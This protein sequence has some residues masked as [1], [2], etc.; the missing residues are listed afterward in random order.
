MERG[1]KSSTLADL[2]PL[3][4][5]LY[6]SAPAVRFKQDGSWV[7]RS[8]DEVLETVRSLSLGLIELGVERGDKVSILAN[9]RPEWTYFDFAALSAGAVVV[10]IYQTNSPQECQYVLENS[11]AKV[12]VVEDDEQMEKIR[13]VRDRLPLLEH[14]VRMT[15]AGEDAI[16]LEDLAARG[17]GRDPAEWEARWQAVTPEDI[18]TFIYTSGTTGPPKGCII[19][20]GNYRAMLDMVNETS[21]IEEED[22]TYLYLPLAHS[23]AL[24]IQLGSFDLGATI[25]YWERDPLKILPNLGELK[26]TYFPSVPRIFEKIYT[27]ATS[28]MEKEGGIKKA[29]FEW[30]IGVGKKMRAA[31][32]EGRKPG[33]LLRKQYEFADKRVLSKIR[34][35]FGGKLR[36]AVSGA[37]P[38]SPE[39]LR[40]FD[41]AGVLVLEGWGMTE[42]STAA[43][44]STP[45][46]FK[47]GT[48]GKPFPG[49]EVKIAADGEILVKGPN[50]FQGYYKNQEATRE[51]IVDGWLHTGDIGEIDA[52]GFIKIT[53]RKKDII[54][55]A[56]GKNITPANLENE[57]KQHPLVSQCVVVGDR[58]PYLVALVTLDPEDAVAYAKEHGLP[59]DPAELA[60]NAEVR[61]AIEGHLAKINENFARVEQVKKVAILPRDLSQEGGELTPTLKVKRA[62]VAAKH[63]DEIEQLYAS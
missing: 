35:L 6:D 46:D 48:I 32:R 4:A 63:E 23:F 57:I 33:F 56:G 11:D 24:L 1:T 54:I 28:G 5:K 34:G 22:L 18:C 52:D 44:I 45:E 2:L 55:T 61:R 47:I 37:A 16:S 53:G 29:V 43:T 10:P 31:E 12:V 38:I 59:E 15:G 9:T 51:T 40:F 14:V 50:V 42:T 62:V 49:C 8:F 3:S 7:D 60:S 13:A 39:I 21:T 58:K 41:A 27:A 26:P 20:H 30:S 19:S 36:L 25:A 17:A